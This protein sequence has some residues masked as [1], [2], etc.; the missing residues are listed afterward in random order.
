M[1]FSHNATVLRNNALFA[2]AQSIAGGRIDRREGMCLLPQEESTSTVSEGI[3]GIQ[4]SVH[5]I[6]RENLH[7][8]NPD[9]TEITRHA[10]NACGINGKTTTN[11]DAA[12]LWKTLNGK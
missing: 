4:E 8:D 10:K 9:A 6:G 2:V 11:A 12:V 5:T 1:P 7:R 3:G